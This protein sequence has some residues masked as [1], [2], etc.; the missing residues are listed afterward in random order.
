M[1][2]TPDERAPGAARFE[3]P[4]EDVGDEDVDVL[5][6]AGQ[7]VPAEGAWLWV[8]AG[9]GTIGG[10]I[11]ALFLPRNRPQASGG[12]VLLHLTP[13]PVAD[14]RRPVPT[15]RVRVWAVVAGSLV[16]VRGWDRLDLDEW[17]EAVRATV[18]FAIG[19]LTELEAHHADVGAREQVDVEAAAGATAAGFPSLPTGAT[20]T[21]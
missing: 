21:D 9:D 20:A 2:A 19:A 5:T 8:T 12:D 6:L 18:A 7:R 1:A 10:K 3:I 17:P 14:Q 11:T 4:A 13:G 15:A 16:P